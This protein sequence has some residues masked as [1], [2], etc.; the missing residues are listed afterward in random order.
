[1]LRYSRAVAVAAGMLL[2]T[3]PA[4]AD[5]FG[6]QVHGILG[7]TNLDGV[8]L[9]VANGFTEPALLDARNLTFK[10]P[11]VMRGGGLRLD[12][13]PDDNQVR[14]GT[15]LA[16]FEVSELEVNYAPLP[17]DTSLKVGDSFG[18]SDEIFVGAEVLKGP[19][20]LYIDARLSLSAVFTN[21]E[22]YDQERGLMGTTQYSHWTAGFGPR[23]GALIPIGHSLTA[24][25]GVYHRLIGG[26]EQWHAYVGLG[27]WD[28]G[29]D[30]E[31]SQELKR[32]A[33]GDF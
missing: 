1:M 24:D 19:V 4:A 29:R 11:G 25:V 9:S 32:S 17:D 26:V 2:A 10:T 27:Y 33:R 21:I 5:S 3:L 7:E 22:L 6:V 23:I 12:F 16:F 30:D 14:F 31:F 13:L 28:N 15:G 18:F 8:E 20:Y